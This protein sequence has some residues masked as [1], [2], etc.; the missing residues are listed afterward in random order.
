MARNGGRKEEFRFS[1][2]DL[3]A[4]TRL[5]WSQLPAPRY[6]KQ[7]AGLQPL[8]SVLVGL[9]KYFRG[10][11][12]PADANA[13]YRHFEAMQRRELNEAASAA[14]GATGANV[15]PALLTPDILDFVTLP[16]LREAL[17]AEAK[18]L[19]WGLPAGYG[20]RIWRLLMV[21]LAIQLI[22]TLIY[23]GLATV[24]RRLDGRAQTGA[25]FRLFDLPGRHLGEFDDQE[26]APVVRRR[27]RDAFVASL[28]LM[29]KLGRAEVRIHG[30]RAVRLLVRLEWLIGYFILAAIVYTLG[31]TQPAF[32][33]LLGYL[34]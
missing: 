25:W 1:Y 20:T 17:L 30:G 4:G 16:V 14:L 7:Q 32:G 12:L 18:W 15:W 19:L 29:F 6:W 22:F 31:R 8:S 34:V 27:L 24:S 33:A 21:A 9:E 3:G 26:A 13:A 28:L 11:D 2:V 5:R 10:R 23:H